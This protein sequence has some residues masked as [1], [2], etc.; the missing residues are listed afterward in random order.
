MDTLPHH[1]APDDDR[2]DGHGP[3]LTPLTAALLIPALFAVVLAGLWLATH[4]KAERSPSSVKP[5]PTSA[6][7]APTAWPYVWPAEDGGSVDP[8]NAYG[9]LAFSA[10]T[11]G[12]PQVTATLAANAVAPPPG[13]PDPRTGIVQRVATLDRGIVWGIA[14]RLGVRAAQPQFNGDE[15]TWPGTGLAYNGTTAT[16]TWLNNSPD[17]ILPLVPRDNDTA[18][19]AAR[20]WLLARG[21]V[22]AMAPVVANQ[23]SRGDLAAFATWHVVV[24]HLGGQSDV[25]EI[26]MTVSASGRLSDLRIVHPVVQGTSAYPIVDWEKAWAQVQAGRARD[27][28]GAASDTPITLH[29]DRI[30]ATARMEQSDGASY[31]VPAYAFTDSASGVTVYWPALDPSTYTAP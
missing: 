14:L 10:P 13:R 26:T 11:A 12:A 30:Q 7:P 25:T 31:V 23:V 17:A 19:S 28:D 8:P 22:E 9:H 21:L 18:A 15:I 27:V 3:R 1:P 20:Q 29:V 5:S 6:P 16:F 2:P 24:P 4:T